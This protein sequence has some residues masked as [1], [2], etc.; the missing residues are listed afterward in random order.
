MF[1]GQLKPEDFAQANSY[2]VEVFVT[3]NFH[4]TSQEGVYFVTMIFQ[5]LMVV[6]CCILAGKKVG[7]SVS[8]N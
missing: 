6:R 8:R 1:Q 7:F 2:R 4:V 5:L 3:N